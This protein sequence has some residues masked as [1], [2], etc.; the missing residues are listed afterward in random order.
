[1]GSILLRIKHRPP[2]EYFDRFVFPFVSASTIQAKRQ[3]VNWFMAFPAGAAIPLTFQYPDDS[4]HTRALLANRSSTRWTPQRLEQYRLPWHRQ[5]Y[6]A[7]NETAGVV[8]IRYGRCD[9]PCSLAFS[10]FVTTAD[11]TRIRTM[12]LDLR[13]NPGGSTPMF[14]ARHLVSAPIKPYWFRTRWSVSYFEAQMQGQTL[15][16]KQAYLQAR[17]LPGNFGV[18]WMTP[19]TPKAAMSFLEP[20]KVS[21]TGPLVILINA[22]TGSAAEDLAALLSEN[23]PV[24]IIGEPS[25]GSTGQ[26]LM[27]QLPG[28]GSAR[29][30]TVQVKYSDGREFVGVGIQPDIHV[31]RTIK[32][33]AEG[34]DEVL[35]AAERFIQEQAP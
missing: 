16:E 24:T 2:Q 34:R 9:D 26:P 10:K 13:G 4:V 23:R 33:I 7:A 5:P 18:E 32:A 17:D 3:S 31:Q 15:P 28:G 6:F 14:V 22:E 27:L 25:G 1:V 11:R 20:E 8:H 12:I 35:D 19:S 29:I 30:C 21:Y